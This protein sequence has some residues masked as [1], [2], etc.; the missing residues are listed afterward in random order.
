MSSGRTTPELDIALKTTIRIRSFVNTF[1]LDDESERWIRRF[2]ERFGREAFLAV[3]DQ[4]VEEHRNRLSGF[5]K[6]FRP[7]MAAAAR[8]IESEEQRVGHLDF[9]ADIRRA[10]DI[11]SAAVRYT[12][13]C[14]GLAAMFRRELGHRRVKG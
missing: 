14:G 4:Y 12:D 7:F 2:E 1:V 10:D 13:R 8:M 5:S 11:K 9:V 6:T 3:L